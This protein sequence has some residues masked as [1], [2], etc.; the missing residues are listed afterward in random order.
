MAA[1]SRNQPV[2]SPLA[3]DSTAIGQNPTLALLRQTEAL[4]E[5]QIGLE[6]AWS[7]PGIMVG[8]YNQGARE[9]PAQLRFRFGLTL[10]V[11]FGQYR[12]RTA[13]AQTG[14]QLARQRTSAQ[15]Q[16]LS[17]DLQQAQG[18]FLKFGQSLDY[19]EI[20][21]LRQSDDL[22]STARRL[23]QAGQTDYVSFIRTV[24]DAYAIRLRYIETLRSYNQS[25]LT[26]NYLTGL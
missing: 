4:S 19:F 7:L 11:W 20:T 16:T 26:I 2:I 14:L 10:P 8:Y 15:L 5:G 24:N 1:L 12:S 3:N 22:I 6:R 25:L 13:A 17:V 18:D 21:G 9:T 23:F